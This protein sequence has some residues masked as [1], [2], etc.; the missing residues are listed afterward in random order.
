[1]NGP[2]WKVPLGRRDGRISRS[3]DALNNLPAPTFNFAQLKAAFASKGLNVKDLVV[4]SGSFQ[5]YIYIYIFSLPLI[6]CN[7]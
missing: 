1:M 7:M 3:N 4:L 2:S 5:L 6:K